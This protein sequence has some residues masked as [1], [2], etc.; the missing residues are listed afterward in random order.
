LPGSKPIV[1]SGTPGYSAV[2]G[3]RVTIFGVTSFLGRYV[4]SK[5]GEE[6]FPPHALLHS[7]P[8]LQHAVGKM[9]TQVIIPY[10]DEDEARVFKPMG[11]LGQIVRMVRTF[12]PHRASKWF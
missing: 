5:L 9:G 6:T 8:S 10:R 12:L 7:S 4:A 3:H 11:D 1:A 2:S